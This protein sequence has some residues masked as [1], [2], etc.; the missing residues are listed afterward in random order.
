MEVSAPPI[1]LKSMRKAH[2]FA[3]HHSLFIIHHSNAKFPFMA[4]IL[5]SAAGGKSKKNR[6][7]SAEVGGVSIGHFQGV[8]PTGQIIG[9]IGVLE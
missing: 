9:E 8:A 4:Q 7:G 6:K 1:Y 3:I 2:T 5:S